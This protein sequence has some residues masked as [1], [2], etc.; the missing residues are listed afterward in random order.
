MYQ[1]QAR[2]LR[3]LQHSSPCNT[4]YSV[5]D[6]ETTANGVLEER[7]DMVVGCDASNSDGAVDTFRDVTAVPADPTATSRRARLVAVFVTPSLCSFETS[8]RPIF[9][10]SHGTALYASLDIPK[11]VFQ[12]RTQHFPLTHLV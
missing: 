12:A 10:A 1:G 9:D 5:M 8:V 6:I 7:T 11:Q 4:Y 2:R 3:R